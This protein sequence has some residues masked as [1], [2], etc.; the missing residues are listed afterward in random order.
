MVARSR[1]LLAQSS[2]IMAHSW[3]V[4]VYSEDVMAPS[5]DV[6][7]HS[8]NVMAHS[9]DVFAN[10]C[11]GGSFVALVFPLSDSIFSNK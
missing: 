10:F 3:D 11:S 4:V 1:N 6:V 5:G 9:G 2:E 7:P 8:I